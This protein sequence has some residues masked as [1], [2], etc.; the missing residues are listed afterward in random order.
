M[1]RQMVIRCQHAT[2]KDAREIAAS[3]SGVR[4]DAFYGLLWLRIRVRAMAGLEEIM[5]IKNFLMPML[6]FQK[7]S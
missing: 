7:E 4:T 1:Y 2:K 3:F 6:R 5:K